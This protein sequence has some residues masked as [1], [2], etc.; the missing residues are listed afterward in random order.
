MKPATS[1]LGSRQALSDEWVSLLLRGVQLD[2]WGQLLEAA[3]EYSKLASKIGD[4]YPKLQSSADKDVLHRIVLCLSAR[5]QVINSGPTAPAGAAGGPGGG[6][7]NGVELSSQDLRALEGV[8]R[9]VLVGGAAAGGAYSGGFVG[10]SSSNPSLSFPIPSFKWQHVTPIVPQPSEIVAGEMGG[11]EIGGRNR[12]SASTSSSFMQQQLLAPGSSA[13][14]QLLLA[15]SSAG[16]SC[17]SSS[18][19]EIAH[20]HAALAAVNGTVVV[21]KLDK[22]G[23][24]DAEINHG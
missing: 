19:A 3:E 17:S 14:R 10:G 16:G 8:L 22:I 18:A 11:E 24:K 6:S 4:H 13:Q 2:G 7:C 9:S 12:A 15:T 20:T 23:L 5:V 1:S 21:L